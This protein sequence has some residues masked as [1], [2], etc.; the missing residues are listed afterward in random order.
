[1]LSDG[2]SFAAAFCR[3]N[4]KL[5]RHKPEGTRSLVSFFKPCTLE[6]LSATPS[7]RIVARLLGQSKRPVFLMRFL[8][9]TIG[10]LK[11][12]SG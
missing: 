7:E 1:M 11:A 10:V 9:P 3:K 5:E 12:L 6:V 2:P 4:G 8:F